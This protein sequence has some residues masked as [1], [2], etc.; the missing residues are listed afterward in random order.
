[1]TMKRKLL[2]CLAVTLLSLQFAA[3]QS[4][5]WQVFVERDV[6]PDGEDRLIF[7]N[8]L[9][10]AETSL[11]V[12]GERYTVL[13]TGVL[14]ENDIDGQ[15]LVAAPDGEI[16]PHPL[17]APADTTRRIDWTVSA[18]GRALAWTITDGTL[19]ALTTTT[20]IADGDTPRQVFADGPHD[21]IRAFPVAFNAERSVLY[22]DYQP[23]TIAD[24]TP[25]RQYAA[26]FS[27]DLET[28]E[29]RSLPGEA[30][31]FCGGGIGSGRFL[32]LTLAESGFDLRVV[33]LE[34]GDQ[35]LISGVG[36]SDYTQGGDV[37]IAPDGTH[38]VY[39]LA[40]VRGFGTAEQ[41]LQTTFVLVDLINFSQTPLLEVTDRFLRPVAWTDDASAV[42]LT[43]PAADGT[44]KINIALSNAQSNAQSSAQNAAQ[45]TL[46][47][48]AAATY[49]GTMLPPQE[50]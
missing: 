17:I 1:M 38:A 11:T 35:R 39:A 23:D 2:L 46:E 42:L 26:L 49:L 3:A 15:V 14:F 28:G 9:S 48:I 10:G 41:T 22:M 21:G 30:G 37:L 8:L 40:Q 13:P 34:T 6:N 5:A 7:V 20:W 29:T 32:R 33:N 18:D 24:F 31:C 44:W 4:A 19:D 16:A 45:S 36:L 47:N 25:F 12:N 27:L 50:R 43:S